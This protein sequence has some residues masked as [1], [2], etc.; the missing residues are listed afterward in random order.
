MADLAVLAVGFAVI[1]LAAILLFSLRDWI[2]GHQLAVWGGLVGILVFLGLSHAMAHVLESKPFLF[3]GQSIA[4]TVA[5]L[6]AALFTGTAGAWFLFET[7]WVRT[8]PSKFAWGAIAF[9]ALHSVGDGLV[10]GRGFVGAVIPFVPIDTLTI[11]A[12]IIHRFMEGAILVVAALAASWRPPTALLALL[13]ALL[14]IPA[15]FAPGLFAAWRGLVVGS[16]ITTA[17]TAFLAAM[18][19]GFVLVLVARGILPVVGGDTSARWV[20]WAAIGF[21]GM[22]FVHFLVE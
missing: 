10:L 9:L 6:L 19:A 20:M 14:A 17:L 2:A 18:E 13:V 1:P 21:I 16:T 15:A 22:S 3:G 7:R 4:L 11:S 12:T 8:K 5:F